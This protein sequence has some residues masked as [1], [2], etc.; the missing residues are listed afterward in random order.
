MKKQKHVTAKKSTTDPVIEKKL[1]VRLSLIIALFAF[2]L[3]SNTI[4][5]GFVL[6]D[7]SVVSENTL[8]QKG[9]PA[10]KTIMTQPYRK[11]YTDD[12]NNLYRPLSKMMFAVE[13]QI[14]PGNPHIHHTMNVLLYAIECVLLFL[15]LVRVTK[16]NVYILFFSVML[17]AAHPVHTEVVANIKSRDEILSMLFIVL[18]LHF[19]ISYLK[20]SKMLSMAGMLFCFFLALLSKESAIVFVAIVPLVMYFFTE[21]SKSRIIRL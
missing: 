10:L 12:E 1:L 15:L 14:S 8:T 3:Y 19:V 13:W 7:V 16:I 18:S 11:G 21:A 20:N 9:I 2:L 5:H 17:F 4:K 6:D